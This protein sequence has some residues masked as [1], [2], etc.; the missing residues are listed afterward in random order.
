M[1]DIHLRTGDRRALPYAYLLGIDYARSTGITLQYTA[2]N[3]HIRGRNLAQLYDGF[4]TQRVLWITEGMP[5]LDFVVPETAPF[6]GEITVST[7]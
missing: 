4:I 1:L 2:A 3:V 6:V 5:S 7:R